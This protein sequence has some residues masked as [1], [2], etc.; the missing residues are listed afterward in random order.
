MTDSLFQLSH[1]QALTGSLLSFFGSK[2]GTV[3]SLVISA[4]SLVTLNSWPENVLM[5]LY[6]AASY[7]ERSIANVN[8]GREKVISEPH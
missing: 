8:I 5:F 3:Y 1:C 7:E 6:V 2:P 4:V